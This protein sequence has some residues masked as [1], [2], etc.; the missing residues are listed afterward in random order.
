MVAHWTFE[1]CKHG[2]PWTPPTTMICNGRRRCRICHNAR[3]CAYITKRYRLD[4]AFRKKR[5]AAS[6]ARHKRL[7]M[8][9]NAEAVPTQTN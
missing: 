6:N 3:T 2:H 4:P 9:Q 7:R 1:C 8:K 5:C